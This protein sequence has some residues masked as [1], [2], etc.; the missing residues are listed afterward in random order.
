[1]NTGHF[2]PMLC[3][4]RGFNSVCIKGLIHNFRC[5]FGWKHTKCCL[6]LS[7]DWL[8]LSSEM[9]MI[10]SVGK[11]SL[12]DHEIRG[13]VWKKGTRCFT[14]RF[15]VGLIVFAWMQTV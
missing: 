3:I 15:T 2:K 12:A 8:K 5:S 9:L 10:P 11:L 4:R 7:G 13:V 14:V 1:M 6:A